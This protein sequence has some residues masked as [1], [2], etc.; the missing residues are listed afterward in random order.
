MLRTGRIGS[1]RAG[2]VL[3]ACSSGWG[4][5]SH[6]TSVVRWSR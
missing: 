1:A 6:A 4:G 2:C 5:G 3:A